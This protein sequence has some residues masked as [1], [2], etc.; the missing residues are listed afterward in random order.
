MTHVELVRVL[1]REWPKEAD[2]W[3]DNVERLFEIPNERDLFYR[4]R[5]ASEGGSLEGRTLDWGA[6]IVYL[7]RDQV[8]EFL[9]PPPPVKDGEAWWEEQRRETRQKITAL[10][11]TGDYGLVAIEDY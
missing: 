3:W 11:T 6:S 9:G 4:I 8:L 10:P 7:S 2:R 5:P 1:S